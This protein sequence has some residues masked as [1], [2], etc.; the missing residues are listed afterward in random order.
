MKLGRSDWGRVAVVLAL[1]QNLSIGGQM[2]NRLSVRVLELFESYFIVIMSFFIMPY[3]LYTSL[4]LY[5]IV[6][7]KDFVEVSQIT[8]DSIPFLSLDP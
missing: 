7:S 5:H 6:M 4:N 3:F 1:A 8:S 2:E